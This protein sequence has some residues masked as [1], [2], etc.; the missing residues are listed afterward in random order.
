MLGLSRRCQQRTGREVFQRRRVILKC[1][2][3]IRLS[4]MAGI[5][6]FGEQ[7]QIAQT[8]FPNQRPVGRSINGSGPPGGIRQ[9]QSKKQQQYPQQRQGQAG[10]TKWGRVHWLVV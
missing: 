9:T 2:V 3:L 5:A 4:G 6:G 10:G 7:G 8:E 1:R